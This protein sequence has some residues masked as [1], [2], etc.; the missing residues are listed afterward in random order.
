MV[1]HYWML[2]PSQKPDRLYRAC[3]QVL[4]CCRLTVARAA[5][6]VVFLCLFGMAALA[7]P[8]G[9]QAP[10]D[11]N[12]LSVD[13]LRNIVSRDGSTI[14]SLRLEG[15]VCA[16][17]RGRN[18]L[19]LQDSSGTVL[20]EAPVLDETVRA[21]ERVAV[22]MKNC[23]LTRTQNGVRLGAGPVVNNDG[24]HGAVVK[25]GRVFLEA[26]QQPI[27]VTWFNGLN[28]SALKVEYRRPRR[29]ASGDSKYST[30]PKAWRG[31]RLER[32]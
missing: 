12:V 24:H 26:G 18:L 14:Q 9:L 27:R 16:V 7:A 13:E 17:A 29:P 8:G 3:C 5:G 11:S 30:F 4:R 19:V 21:G 15:V 1:T 25:S 20:L 28:P 2:L 10:A 31:R 22:T 6:F 23:A 32:F